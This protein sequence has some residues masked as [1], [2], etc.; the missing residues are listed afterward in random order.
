MG[1]SQ[2][3]GGEERQEQEEQCMGKASGEA[4]GQEIHGQ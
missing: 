1:R 3:R 4:G 2:C